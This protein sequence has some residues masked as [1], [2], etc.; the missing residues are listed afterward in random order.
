MKK[1]SA[2]VR[3]W[4]RQGLIKGVPP[5]S[6]KEGWQIKEND[7]LTFIK[8][9]SP[10]KDALFNTT[11]NVSEVDRKRIRSEMWWEMANKLIFEGF[12]E[13][14]KKQ[15]QECVEH[16]GH[17]KE[18]EKYVWEHVSTHKRGYA[19]PRIPYL[20]D[21]FLFDDN[22]ILMDE[23]YEMIEEKILYA[24]IEYLRKKKASN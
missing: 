16:K 11:N 17:S 4:L 12:I 8:S 7:L 24:L 22:R 14:K 5:A 21:A 18:F 2:S 1:V 10:E 6:R 9:R 23:N 20:L 3:R 13:P 19:T 15:V